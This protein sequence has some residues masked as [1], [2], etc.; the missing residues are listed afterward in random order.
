MSNDPVDAN[1]SE[2]AGEGAPAEGAA[3]EGAA[4]EDLGAAWGQSVGDAPPATRAAVS[5]RRWLEAAFGLAIR[6]T[7]SIMQI[8]GQAAAERIGINATDLNC[9]NIIS[10]TGPM[11]AGELARQTGLTTAS[12]TGV[13]DRLA[14]S[15]FVR[16]E[17]DATDRRRVVIHII[18]ERALHDVASVFLPM[19]RA[20]QATASRYSDEQLTLILEFQRDTE[21]ILRDHVQRLR[22]P[23]DAT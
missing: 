10:L 20:W 4:G 1:L 14:E 12:I 2:A 23:G 19:V 5:E 18:P 17:R 6:R 3:G 15:G 8:L 21:Q 11:T 22:A 13:I 16:R 9:L 7:G